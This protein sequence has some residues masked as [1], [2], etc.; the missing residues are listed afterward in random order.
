MPP[1]RASTSKAPAMTKVSIRKLVADNVTAALEAQVV[2]MANS[3][4]PNRNTGPTGILVIN[5]GNY[6]E[7]S[8]VNLSISMVRKEQ[9]T[10]SAGLN[11]QNQYTLVADV[12]E[13]TK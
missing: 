3:N 6:K 12:L 5:T 11:K 10:L 13:K 4:N 8:A 7:L 9:L 2:M 1:K